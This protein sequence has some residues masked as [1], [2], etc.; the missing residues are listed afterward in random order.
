MADFIWYELMTSD[1]DAAGRFY[2]D[3]V[4]WTIGP[5]PDGEMDYRMIQRSDG[6]SAGGVLALTAEMQAGGAGP[7]WLPYLFAADTDAKVAQIEADG[8][9]VQMPA[10][11]L[12]VGRI[13]MVK[14]PQGVPIYV[15]TPVPPPGMEGMESDVFSVDKPQHARW[16]E[17]ASPDLAASKEFYSR[18]FGFEFNN[19]MPMG[20]MGDYCF[21]DHEGRTLGA[22][23]QAQ[24]G[25]P[26][27][28]LT[29]FGVPSI[30]EAK[31]RVEAGGGSVLM[32]PHEVPGGEWI[33]VA[34]DPQGAGFG[35]VGPQGE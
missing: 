1:P 30:A 26:Q 25:Q 16:N 13:A 2:G 4:G 22:M 21:I 27:V 32:G 18:H 20:E 23:M 9:A 6:G 12:P 29:Y 24:P 35:L 34:L 33:I 19:S 17:L 11:T 28:W 7:T 10:M 14:D 15:M 31:R 8:G 5:R 3:V